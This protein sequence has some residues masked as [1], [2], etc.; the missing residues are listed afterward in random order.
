MAKFIR[1]LLV[2][3]GTAIIVA[4][5][6]A[7]YKQ[8][9]TNQ[10]NVDFSEFIQQVQKQPDSVVSVTLGQSVAIA[11]LAGD[12]TERVVIPNAEM[13]KELGDLLQAKNI[14]FKGDGSNDSN[15]QTWIY[16][17]ST[18][19]PLVVIIIFVMV[20]MRQAQSGGSQALSFGRC[21]A[22][23]LTE[24]R[25]K[26]TFADVAGVDEAKQELAEVV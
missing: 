2:V 23:L 11:K 4:L 19:I 13:S 24:N 6:F 26:V 16:A 22:K 25:P 20:I 18:I 5:G 12:A 17:L 15:S 9:A 3:L 8:S 10:K 7:W 14:H 21:R 1:Y